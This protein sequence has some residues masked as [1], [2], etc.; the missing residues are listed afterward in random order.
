[1]FYISNDNISPVPPLTIPPFSYGSNGFTVNDIHRTDLTS[2]RDLLFPQE[3]RG[4]RA[5]K[6][7]IESA[8]K[9]VTKK[10]LEAQLHH[11]GIGFQS[12]AQKGVLQELLEGKIKRGEVKTL[13]LDYTRV[14]QLIF[15]AVQPGPRSNLG[16]GKEVAH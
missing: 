11:Y 5:Q 9:T 10:W 13:L 4:K 1:L 2:L 6:D 12:S 15:E 8:R 3:V 7:A 14:Y 16:D